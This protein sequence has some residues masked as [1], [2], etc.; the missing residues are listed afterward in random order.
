[1][2]IPVFVRTP[3]LLIFLLSLAMVIDGLA[4]LGEPPRKV[5]FPFCCV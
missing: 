2:A 1:M 3:W 4:W 5:E